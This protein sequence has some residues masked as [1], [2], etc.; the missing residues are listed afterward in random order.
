MHEHTCASFVISAF[1]PLSIHCCIVQKILDGFI[2]GAFGSM[3]PYLHP[4][5]DIRQIFPCH[6]R[7]PQLLMRKIRGLRLAQ[8]GQKMKCQENIQADILDFFIRIH[9]LKS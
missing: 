6:R 1:I 8:S 2:K 9:G 3:R 5:T 7:V 4:G